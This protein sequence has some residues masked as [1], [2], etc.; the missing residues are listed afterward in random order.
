MD[1][2]PVTYAA[3]C[4]MQ[5]SMR[6]HHD[7]GVGVFHIANPYPVSA[8]MLKHAVDTVQGER[9]V[10]TLKACRLA[11]GGPVTE[12]FDLWKA[13]GRRFVTDNTTVALTGSGI[14]CPQITSVDLEDCVRVAL[15]GDQS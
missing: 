1:F 5:I 13:T 9:D 12:T 11:S 15:R 8:D 10:R 6:C 2:T 7:P 3:K 4:M 14:C